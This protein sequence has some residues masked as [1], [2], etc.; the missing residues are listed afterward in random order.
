MRSITLFA[1]VCSIVVCEIKT[2]TGEGLNNACQKLCHDRKK[3]QAVNLTRACCDEASE[4]VL[5]AH[6]YNISCVKKLMDVC[7]FTENGSAANLTWIQPFCCGTDL[8]SDEAGGGF[9]GSR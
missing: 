7:N 9:N 4:C 6:F 1:A 8:D 3:A 2:V 5:P